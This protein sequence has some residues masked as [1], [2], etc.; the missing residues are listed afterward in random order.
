MINE[1]DVILGRNIKEVYRGVNVTVPSD[2]SSNKHGL[3]TNKTKI[4]A[5]TLGD[6]FSPKGIQD[7]IDSPTQSEL[8]INESLGQYDYYKNQIWECYDFNENLSLN[9]FCRIIIMVNYL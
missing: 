3:V 4:F 7:S 2:K 6:I 9:L 1:T 8:Y 5:L